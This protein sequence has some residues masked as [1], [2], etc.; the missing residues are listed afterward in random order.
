MIRL[1]VVALCYILVYAADYIQSAA[2][3][4]LTLTFCFSSICALAVVV[5]IRDKSLIVF[6]YGAVNLI[7]AILSWLMISPL[8]FRAIDNFYYGGSFNFS[9]IYYAI[10][11]LVLFTGGCSVVR[12]AVTWTNINRSRRLLTFNRVV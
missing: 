12:Y 11:L 6:A 10:E 2:D 7:A 4:Y 5:A 8:W 9:L 3:Y 1:L